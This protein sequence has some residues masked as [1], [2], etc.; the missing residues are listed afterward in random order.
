MAEVE[1]P[2]APRHVRRRHRDVEADLDGPCME[3]VDGFGVLEKPRHPGPARRP[4]ERKLRSSSLPRALPVAAQEDLGVPAAG[5]GE[6]W[7]AVALVTVPDE[8]R[9]PAEALE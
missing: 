1:L 4:V 9:L 3:S 7:L 2:D 8:R 6:A 5:S